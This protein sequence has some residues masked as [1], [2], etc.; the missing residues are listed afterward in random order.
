MR[1]YLTVLNHFLVAFNY[2]IGT[3]L[4]SSCIILAFFLVGVV[5]IVTC[6]ILIVYHALLH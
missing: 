3:D 5:G 4:Y 2:T 6:N 1:R